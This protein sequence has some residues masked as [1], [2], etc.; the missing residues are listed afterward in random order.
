MTLELDPVRGLVLSIIVLWIGERITA[1]V[2]F[3]AEPSPP[4]Y[5]PY[6]EWLAQ[7]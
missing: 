3:L 5:S 6:A 7:A 4:S 1:R 2:T